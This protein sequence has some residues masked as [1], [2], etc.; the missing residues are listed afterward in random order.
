MNQA[1]TTTPAHIEPLAQPLTHS[2]RPYCG[3]ELT[4][5]LPAISH[6][7]QALFAALPQVTPHYAVKANP[8]PA[9]LSH[10]QQL[11]VRFEI[12]SQGELDVLQTLGVRGADIIYSHPIK[13]PASIRAAADYGVRWFA[14]DCIEELKSLAIHAPNAHYELRIATDGK[15]AVWPLSTKFGASSTQAQALIDYAGEQQ[16]NLSGITFHVGSQCTRAASWVTA[17]EQ[18]QTL[19]THMRDVGLTPRLLNIG[20]GFPAPVSARTPDIEALACVIRPAL[21]KLPD[22]VHVVAEP[23]RF[24]VGS[25]GTLRCQIINTTTRGEQPWAYL[26]CGYYN[27]LIEMS[28]DFGFSLK[29]E[30][31]GARQGWV[32]AGPTCD[33]LDRFE[34]LYQLPCDSQAGDLLTIANVGAYS[35][36]CAC[37][38]NGFAVPR[39]N[40]T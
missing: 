15:G 14:V 25:A 1:A 22:S 3:P 26:D 4:I 18:A 23:G 31:S 39:V 10:L 12:A 33:S 35:S 24:L 38:F 17:I 7:A 36:A 37:A 19:F 8:H 30:R 11:G 9:I 16:L 6:Q 27:G 21:A 20:G 28:S 2:Q 34:P 40:V 5:A 29:S 32:I 13:T